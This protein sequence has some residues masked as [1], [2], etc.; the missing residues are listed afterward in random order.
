M[1]YHYVFKRRDGF[2]KEEERDEEYPNAYKRI[3]SFYNPEAINLLKLKSDR[4]EYPPAD[5]CF[6]KD[7][8]FYLISSFYALGREI[9]YYEER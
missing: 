2:T 1:I 3:L 7:I 5:I 9:R 8:E 6:R 4:D